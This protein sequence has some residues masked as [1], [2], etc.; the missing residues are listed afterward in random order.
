MTPRRLV[1]RLAEHPNIIGVK[2]CTSLYM[3]YLIEHRPEE[4]LIYTGSDVMLSCYES[5][6]LME[7]SL[8]LL[9]QTVM[10]CLEML[11]AIEHNDI[12]SAIQT[13]EIHSQSQCSFLPEP[14]SSQAVLNYYIFT[15]CACT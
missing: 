11:D 4:F 5:V 6:G 2:E 9:T 13:R 15:T 12:S 8:L 7:L 14:S 10:K 1:G 3:A